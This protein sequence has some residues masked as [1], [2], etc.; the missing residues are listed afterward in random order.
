M[1]RPRRAKPA[2]RASTLGTPPVS[3]P[4]GDWHPGVTPRGAANYLTICAVCYG[5]HATD[6]CNGRSP[7]QNTKRS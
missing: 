1:P 2:P 4:T 7:M 5:G 6:K 3:H